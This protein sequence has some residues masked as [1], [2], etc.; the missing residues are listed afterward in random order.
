MSFEET[1]HLI[2]NRRI[3]PYPFFFLS[4]AN[5]FSDFGSVGR[6]DWKKK[7]LK[8]IHKKFRNIRPWY[9]RTTLK[10]DIHIIWINK[11]DNILYNMLIVLFLLFSVLLLCSFVRLKELFQGKNGLTTNFFFCFENAKHLGRSDDA[12]RRKKRGWPYNISVFVLTFR[13]PKERGNKTVNLR[14]LS[15]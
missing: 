1:W 5:A 3:R 14:Q 11:M 6:S 8:K 15:P 9:P 4:V 2:S 10:V 13:L 12:K 7:E